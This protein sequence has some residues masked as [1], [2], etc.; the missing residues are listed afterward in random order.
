MEKK[1]IVHPNT[2]ALI[3][4]ID[5]TLA[6]T[7]PAHFNAFQKV[8]A[9]YGID[10]SVSLFESLAGVPVGPQMVMLKE[11]FNPDGFVP[12]KV[13]IEK[14]TEYRKTLHEMKPIQ[15]V[16]DLLNSYHG[17]MPIGCG[18]GSDRFAARR[19]LEV[20]N[21]FDKVDA[22]VTCDDVENGKPAPD[23]FLK[24]AEQLG[25]EPRFCQVF[26]DGQPGIDA[27]IAAGMMVTDVRDFL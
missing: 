5:G 11:Q 4:D 12:E 17:K 8:L 1:I 9:P 24:C 14:E 16:F 10:F 25:V 21:V 22:V 19:T 6:D 15:P 13:A 26:E 27:A 7:M 20:I 3:F 23:T 18:T 2:K